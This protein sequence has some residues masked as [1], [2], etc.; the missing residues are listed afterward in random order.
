MTHTQHP[1][2]ALSIKKAQGQL[3]KISEMLDR[4]DYCIDI[5][6]Q[7]LAAIGLLKAAHL[8]LLEDHLTHCF[9]EAMN[10]ANQKKKQAMTEE[11]LHVTKLAH[12]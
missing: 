12:K 9:Q 1:T 4:G 6:Q 11:I 3:K 8:T 10:T 7:N 2:A 5:M